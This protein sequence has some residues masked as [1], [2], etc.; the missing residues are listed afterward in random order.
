MGVMS[1]SWRADR[2]G[3]SGLEVCKKVHFVN[4]SWRLEVSEEYCLALEVSMPHLERL[5]E[6]CFYKH[7]STSYEMRSDERKKGDW[8]V[9]GTQRHM[10][11][12][13]I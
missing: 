1:T 12:N 10:I 13:V 5:T 7:A 8:G 2:D 3:L 11:A 4:S 6:I 9:C